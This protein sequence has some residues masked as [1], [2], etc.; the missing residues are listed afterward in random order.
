MIKQVLKII[1]MNYA[2]RS[3]KK[4]LVLIYLKILDATRKSILFSMLIF[5]IFHCNRSI[6]PI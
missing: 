5:F 1:L 2:L 3:T 4:K 6:S